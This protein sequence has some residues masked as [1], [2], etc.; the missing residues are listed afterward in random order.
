MAAPMPMPIPGLAPGEI[1]LPDGMEHEAPPPAPGVGPLPFNY[2][3]NPDG[4]WSQLGYSHTATAKEWRAP[5][6]KVKTIYER[7]APDH[8]F[9]AGELHE[10]SR[11][12][13]ELLNPPPLSREEKRAKRDEEKA[14]RERRADIGDEARA[15]ED[16]MKRVQKWLEDRVL[17]RRRLAVRFGRKAWN[18]GDALTTTCGGSPGH[19]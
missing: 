15:E 10:L 6:E 17:N 16:E 2:V 5:T 12:P 13:N 14:E 8:L 19:T 11:Q 3:A 7:P 1:P 4:S 9:S 18:Y